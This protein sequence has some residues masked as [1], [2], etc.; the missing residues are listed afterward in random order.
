MVYF[1]TKMKILGYEIKAELLAAVTPLLFTFVTVFY[2][3]ESIKV[4][5][6]LVL[7]LV[8]I[9][10]FLIKKIAGSNFK[11]AYP[12]ILIV[13]AC[14]GLAAAGILTIEKIALLKD[15]NHVTSC[16]LSPVVACSPVINSP[17]ASVF[18][19]PNP[20]FGLFGFGCVLA[21][22][23]TLIAG[24]ANIKLKKWWWH[25][26][27]AGCAAGLIFV[28][29][30][31]YQ[32][33]YDIKSICLYCTAVWAV[34]I[35]LYVTTLR[36]ATEEKAVPL[37]PDA[38]AKFVQKYTLEIIVSAYALVIILIL[39]RFWDYWVSLI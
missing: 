15:P 38:L 26:L 22:G 37:C 6:L 12:Y 34:V 20:S 10:F 5:Y 32:T 4:F 14:I 8:V 16:S 24:G 30:L 9:E 35:P 28:A 3:R 39:Q 13:G 21:A 7:A 18:T 31:I 33:L 2:T 1:L 19:I 25:S 11:K 17:Q 29:W 36:R 23:M 27:L